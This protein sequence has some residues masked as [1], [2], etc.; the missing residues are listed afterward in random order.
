MTF[1]VKNNYFTMAAGVLLVAAMV[2]HGVNWSLL[3]LAYL[4]H[5]VIFSAGIGLATHRCWIH[6][7]ATMRAGARELFTFL[8]AL[9]CHGSVIDWASSHIVHHKYSDG[10]QDSHSPIQHGLPVLFGFYDTTYLGEEMIKNRRFFM[11]LKSHW[12][13]NFIHKNYYSVLGIYLIGMGLLLQ[14]IELFA[15]IVLL[16]MWM[17]FTALTMTNYFCHSNAFGTYQNF[18]V[19]LSKNV[20]WMLPITF[21]ENWHNNH[22]KYDRAACTTEKW[23]EIDLVWLVFGWC[24]KKE[25]K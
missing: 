11:S 5:F 1:N 8:S 6:G 9:A 18:D 14:D 10:V 4:I 22:H 2:W 15:Y 7:A 20:W 3:A 16:P 25:E 19:D 23:W 13:V 24:C 12:I 21:G 17:S